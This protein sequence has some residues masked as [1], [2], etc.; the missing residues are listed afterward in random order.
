MKI[1]LKILASVVLT[2]LVIELIGW[3]APQLRPF[4]GDGMYAVDVVLGFAMGWFI[5]L[6]WQQ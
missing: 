3:L 1:F 5:S 4:I 2:F 6:I